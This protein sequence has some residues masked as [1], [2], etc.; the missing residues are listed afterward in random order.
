M[1]DNKDPETKVEFSDSKLTK[2]SRKTRL[3]VVGALTVTL[4]LGVVVSLA[5]FFTLK[6]STP[7]SDR[8]VDV[9]L[10][11]GDSLTYR[12]DQEIEMDNGDS[13]QRGIRFLRIINQLSGCVNFPNFTVHN[14]LFYSSCSK[15]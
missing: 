7:Q 11:E 3:R 2:S 12:V 13:T 4:L 10:E 15:L 14:S 5:M 1:A 6:E 9:N 8:L